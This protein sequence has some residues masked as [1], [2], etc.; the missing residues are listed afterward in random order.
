MGLRYQQSH[1][2][3]L[4]LC[5]DTHCNL[6]SNPYQLC[7]LFSGNVAV[8]S[9][10]V[11][12]YKASDMNRLMFTFLETPGQDAI[13]HFAINEN[14]GIIHTTSVLDRDVR[15]P[16]VPRCSITVDVA[17]GPAQYF[18]VYVNVLCIVESHTNQS[19]VDVLFGN[20]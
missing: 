6:I 12:K 16:H 20:L 1:T 9:G 17:V 14:T 11:D 10:L 13:N 19:I 4:H 15:C 7:L 5:C 18:Q 2:Y 3:S 8:D